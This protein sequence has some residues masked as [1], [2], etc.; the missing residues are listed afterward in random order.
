MSFEI[1]KF[2]QENKFPTIRDKDMILD[3]RPD[4]N[5]FADHRCKIIIIRIPFSCHDNFIC[6]IVKLF[7]NEKSN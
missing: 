4:V 2:L 6:K 5:P 3:S 1:Q 7:C